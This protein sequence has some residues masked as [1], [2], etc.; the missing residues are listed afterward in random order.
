MLDQTLQVTLSLL[1]RLLLNMSRL[2]HQLR[3]I[4]APMQIM[5]LSDP[6]NDINQ[7]IKLVNLDAFDNPLGPIFEC[8]F[9]KDCF[10]VELHLQFVELLLISR[11]NDFT[12][13]LLQ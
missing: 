10:V 12:Y 3:C 5:Y 8:F 4:R 13:A 11:L 1:A 2:P 9:E 7:A 6:A